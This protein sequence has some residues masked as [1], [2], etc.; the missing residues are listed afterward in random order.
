M[1]LSSLRVF[2]LTAL[3]AFLHNES[4]AQNCVQTYLPVAPTPLNGTVISLPC[5][6]NCTNI[7]FQTPHYKHTS[8]YVVNSIPYSPFPYLSATGAEDPILYSDDQYS[9][10]V[11]L[12]FSFPFYDSIFTKMV[13]GSNGL[14]TFDITNAN[15]A[16]AWPIGP[17][18][19]YAA[20]PQCNSGTS[21]YPKSSVMGAYSDLDPRAIASPVDRKIQWHVEGSAPCR[22]FVISYYHVGVFG[23]NSCGLAN[24][25]TF[26]IVIFESS[27]IVEFHYEHVQ[28]ASSTNG[29]RT[30]AG[31]QNWNRDLAASPPGMN[32]TPVSTSAW[33]LN[34]QAYRF[35]PDGGI[36]NFISSE[37]TTFAGVHVAWADTATTTPGLLDLHFPNICTAVPSTQFV[38]KTF[39]ISNTDPN[40]LLYTF[41]TVTIN[42]TTNLNATATSTATSCGPPTGTIIVTVPAN[43]GTGPFT[44]TLDAGA[45]QST[46]NRTYTFTSVAAGPHTVFVT[47]NTGCSNTIPITVTSTGTFAVTATSTPTACSGINNGTIT[48]NPPTGTAP[49]QYSING[50]P[51]QISNLFSNLAPGNY[52]VQVSDAG[53]CSG[54]TTVNIVMGPAIAATAASTATTCSNVNNGTIT[55]TPT[56]GTG[57]YQYS[58]DGAAYQGSNTFNNVSAGNHFVVVQDAFGCTSNTLNVNVAQGAALTGTAISTSTSC[59]GVNNGTITVTPTSGSSPYQYTLDAGAFQA[60]NVFT[61]VAAGN[62]TV[63]FKDA[64]GCSS[65]NIPVTVTA[66]GGLTANTTTT[67]TS[68]QGVNNGTISI[69][70]TNGTAPYQYSLDGGAYQAANVFT[71]VAAGAHFIVI[72]DVLGCASN[73]INVTVAAGAGVTATTI[74]TATSCNGINN[75]T[76]TV[77]PTNGTSPYQYSL[78]GGAYQAGNIFTNVSAGPHTVVIQDA[79][80]CV[81]AN[82]PVTVAA[83]AGVSGTASSTSTSCNGASNG[84]I[85]AIASNGTAP[86]QYSLDGGAYQPGNSFTNVAAGSHNIVIRDAVGCISAQIPVSVAVGPPLNVT[87][88][89]TNTSCNGAAN[90]SITLTP[91]NGNAPYQYS[92]NGGPS[93]AGNVFNNLTS[94]NY[95][96]SVTDVNGCSANN[97]PATI[98]AGTGLTA[99]INQTNITCNGNANGSITVNINAPA[100]P[101]FQYSLDNITFQASNIFTGLG[102]ANYTVYFRD[103]LGCTGTQNII[104]T[105]PP[106]LVMNISTQPVRCNGQSNGIITVNAS[107]GATPY[108]YSLDGVN[109]QNSNIFNV[110]AGTYTVYTKDNNGCIKIQPN[111]TITQPATLTLSAVTQNASCNGGADGIITATAAGGNGNFQYS[112][113]GVNF[114]ASNV[115]NVIPGNFTVTVKDANNCLMTANATVGLTSNLTFTKGNDTIICE[116]TSAQLYLTTNATQF[117][118][119]PVAGLNNPAISNPVASP[120]ITTQYTV[121]ATLG[122]CSTNGTV[123]VTVNPAP[124]ANAGS[125]ADICFGQDA[126]LAGSGGTKYQWLPATYL[127]N[128]AIANPQVIKPQRTIQYS[129]QVIDANGCKSL[130]PDVVKVNVTPPIKVFVYPKDS[131]VAEGDQIQ[132]TA[133]SVAASY[134]W[135]NASTLSNATI[136]NPVAMIPPGSIGNIY[137]Y[138]VTATTS[139]GCTGTATI[140]LKVYKGPDIYMVSGFT[141]NGDGKNERFTP[142]PVGI[143]QINYF[144]VY[145]RWG[146]LLF[147]STKLNEGWDGSYGGRPQAAGAYVWVVQGVTKDDKIISK[148]G[149]VTLIR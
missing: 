135:S 13:V 103:N 109:Y 18:I 43:L 45:P 127:S 113:D 140:V 37:L 21:Y 124:V 36:S 87:L 53:G 8:T 137:T 61:N 85:T 123:T 41:D 65:S 50:G 86:Y 33:Q 25:H 42:R 98:N 141:P 77:T 71:N 19:P 20:G 16:N 131:I 49:Y 34:N 3:I 108:Q 1:K 17:Q 128:S 70:P 133:S 39:F 10:V 11:P 72:Q 148:K 143:K 146:Q 73:T 35:T 136:A 138:T 29:G 115:F 55:V 82:I 102:A 48:V 66:G 63:T 122:N 129:L 64:I 112:I 89:T 121:I 100:T 106:A 92:L 118:W 149:T 54:T 144:R 9:T 52:T 80:G 60:S 111:T 120:T 32:A 24:P 142:F 104:I 95:T 81:S 101:P 40:N 83:G 88:A 139:A 2:L 114:Q 56:S 75:G 44:Y 15:C 28:C 99:T 69:T 84:T 5:G 107:G 74:T 57:P 51:T 62:H 30:I 12:P 147:S 47:D 59:V 78:D 22:K 145:N 58:L 94:G 26:Q 6:Q 46:A 7:D 90:G 125:D 79:A 68:C 116:G 105:Q 91:V 67:A 126:Q 23:N 132:L 97:L 96:V 93:Q 27:G 38:V 130:L 117:T 134:T 31:V 76:I 4:V 119:A 110:V 14:I